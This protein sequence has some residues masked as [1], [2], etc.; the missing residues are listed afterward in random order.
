MLKSISSNFIKFEEL[1]SVRAEESLENSESSGSSSETIS[2]SIDG[3]Q[4]EV[5]RKEK[6]KEK[7]NNGPQVIDKS[8]TVVC[9]EAEAEAVTTTSN[10]SQNYRKPR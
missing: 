8:L 6:E 10:N 3:Y 7:E 2:E 9:K 5:N 4:W 1:N